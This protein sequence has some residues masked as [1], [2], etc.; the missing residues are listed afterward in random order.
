MLVSFLFV[1]ACATESGDPGQMLTGTEES[2]VTN[3]QTGAKECLGHKQLIC[4]IPPGNPANA[5][6]ICVGKPAVD[7]H[8]SHHGDGVGACA[9]EPTDP[10]PDGDLPPAGEGGD[11]PIL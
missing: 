8:V 6:T 10:D 3:A 5:H 1:T 9:A 7:P 4:H 2:Y 11:S